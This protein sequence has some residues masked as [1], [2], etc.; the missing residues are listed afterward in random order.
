MIK[1]LLSIT[2]L[3]LV[4]TLTASA[5]LTGNT[6]FS[7]VVD[8]TR[9]VVPTASVSVGVPETAL[10]DFEVARLNQDALAN[11]LG[12]VTNVTFELQDPQ[13]PEVLGELTGTAVFSQNVSSSVPAF[14]P[15]SRSVAK[16][17]GTYIAKDLNTQGDLYSAS[18]FIS[19]KTDEQG[20]EIAD[21]YEIYNVYG[22]QSIIEMTINPTTGE[23]E[24]PCQLLMNHSTYGEVKICPMGITETGGFS[25]SDQNPVKGTIDE[26]GVITLGRWG[27][28]IT[29]EGSYRGRGFNFFVSS[30]WKPANANVKAHNQNGGTDVEYPIL[31]EQDGPN[32]VVFYCLSGITNEIISA[33]LTSNK[34]AVMSPQ[35]VYTN[36]IYGDFYMYPCDWNSGNPKPD[37]KGNLIF[38]S[39]GNVLKTAG[40][41]IAAKVLPSQYIGYGY[42]DIVITLDKAIEFP[43]QTTETLKGEGTETSPYLVSTLADLKLLADLVEGGNT[44]AGKVIALT[45]DIDCSGLAKSE[46]VPVGDAQNPFE[47]TFDGRGYAI[48]NLYLDNKGFT[49]TGIFGYIGE[50]GKVKNLD[51]DHVVVTTVGA[52]VGTIAGFNYGLIENCHVSSGSVHCDGEIAGGIAG[53]SMGTISKCSFT[54]SVTSIGSAAGIVGQA[55]GDILDCSV[56]GIITL[57]GYVSAAARDAA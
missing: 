51:A 31:V 37:S 11:K 41:A 12:S 21:T 36:A 13:L 26:N 56:N 14:A 55:Y 10:S 42:S 27:V 9:S 23:V 33:R 50:N 16:P 53:G 32:G 52:N 5:L 43:A 49:N 39:D 8:H 45:A 4:T 17:D 18:M 24:I 25:F 6:D 46:Y 48:K 54:G 57:D 40:W 44:F 35:K 1:K 20:N 22:T 28:I 7:A 47:G 30:E 2:A 15:G 19:P 29:Q 34:T 38:T 3:G